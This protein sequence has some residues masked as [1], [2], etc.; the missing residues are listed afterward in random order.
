[1]YENNKTKFLK[2]HELFERNCQTIG[3]LVKVYN[4]K[5]CEIFLAKA[6]KIALNG[7]LLVLVDKKLT[8]L[9]YEKYSILEI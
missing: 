9:S 8:K 3:K 2:L 5:T 4:V 6:V 7:E 1:M